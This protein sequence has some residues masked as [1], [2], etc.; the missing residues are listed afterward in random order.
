MKISLIQVCFLLCCLVGLGQSKSKGPDSAI[1]N[2]VHTTGYKTSEYGAIPEYLKA[3]KGKKTLILI[4]G[5][6]FDASVFSDFIK[7]NKKNFTM[8]AITIPGYGKTKA[9]P[10]PVTDSSYGDQNWNKG[11]IEGLMKLIVKEKLQIPVIVGHFVEGTQL[12]LRMAID[13]P[14]KVGSIII[15][16]GPAKFIYIDKGEPK[17][18]PLKTMISYVD[19]YTAPTWF[20]TISR[21]NFSDGNYLPEIYSLD[22]TQALKLWKQ[23]ASQPLPVMIRY[24]CEFFASDVTLELEKIKC[25]VLILRATF[26][27]RIL[28]APINNYVRPQFIDLWNETTLKNQLIK[29]KDI[30]GAASFVWKDNPAKVYAEIKIFLSKPN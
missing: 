22:S 17:L 11:V 2:L 12:A 7:A 6:G 14:D 27:T 10:M 1:N 24:L 8:Y 5:L 15:L 16:G 19:K 30:Q 4:P 20:K 25:P 13:H 26:N 9:P 28:Q 29:V 18:Y 23:S 21:E 3:G